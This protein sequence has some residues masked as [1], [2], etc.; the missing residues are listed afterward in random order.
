ML[1]GKARR[2]VVAS[3]GIIWINDDDDSGDTGGTNIP[4]IGAATQ[5]LANWQTSTVNGAKDLVDLFPVALDIQ[6]LLTVLPP[7]A[8]VK[9]KLKQ[10]DC[11]LNFVCTN[12]TRDHA[13]D[14]QRQPQGGPL[15][16][17]FGPQLTQAPTVASKQQVTASGADLFD[18]ATGST[19][20]LDAIQNHNGGVLLIEGRAVTTAP[21]V[22]SVEKDGN[23]IAEVK[24]YLSI[25]GVESMY[26]HLNLRSGPDAPADADLVGNLSRRNGNPDI[27]TNLGNPANFPD[28]SADEP[29]FIFVVGSNVG[30]Q[31]SRGWESEAFKRLYWS[32][33]SSGSL[34]KSR[35]VGVS[36]F[37]DP[38]ANSTEQI[39][40][41]HLSVRNAFATASKLKDKVNALTGSKTIAGHSLGCGVIAAAIADYGM[42]VNHT[43]FVDAAIARE[44][45]DGRSAGDETNTSGVTATVGMTLN[46]WRA[47]DPTFYAANWNERFASTPTDARY[48]NLTW[49]SRF[50]AAAGTI[51]NFY[52]STEDVLG[53][54]DGDVPDNVIAAFL[55]APSDV[56]SYVWVY[57]EKAKGNRQ[58]YYVWPSHV[59]STYGGWGMNLKDPI[60]SNDPLYWKWVSNDNYI[61]RLIKTPAEI[62][63]VSDAV[64][65]RHP[66]F[67]PGW[68]VIGGQQQKIPVSD[69]LPV[70]NAPSWIYDLYGTSGG[71]H[72]ADYAKRAQLL[73]EFVP[74]LSLPT[75]SRAV[76]KFLDRNY[77]S[78]AKFATQGWPRGFDSQTKIARWRHSDMREVA[79]LYQSG[80]WDTFVS[81]SQ[82]P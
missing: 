43:C 60:L 36:W 22:L 68:G 64:L 7:S 55:N 53:R 47:Y 35:F 18:S 51:T 82:Q 3:L 40:D 48:T 61:G 15:T 23:V 52:S 4:G 31:N 67:E 5:T 29:W 30:G 27:A 34:F 1:E 62:G 80:L 71:T 38:Y 17:G 11:A 75:G 76:T 79:Y 58:D 49:R 73:A 74:A 44:A 41:Y 24:L 13:F 63:T 14:Y 12:L 37:G 39:Y 56:A 69:V 59:G 8:S 26:R 9:Y 20:F 54:Y 32:R 65:R 50:S 10:A 72:A 57:Q 2:R 19:A 78:P 16:T 66:V 77:D 6:Q 70:A 33:D 46:I 25:S 45:F 42:T 81:I 28:T 21:L